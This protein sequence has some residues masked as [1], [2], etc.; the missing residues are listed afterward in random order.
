MDTNQAIKIVKSKSGMT[1]DEARK[2]VKALSALGII[3]LEERPKPDGVWAV[4]D[5]V[6]IWHGC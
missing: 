2:F 4:D 6:S 3:S 5:D 1:D